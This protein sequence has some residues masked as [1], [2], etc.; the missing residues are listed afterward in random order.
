MMWE[1]RTGQT[2]DVHK[3][4]ELDLGWIMSHSMSLSSFKDQFEEWSIINI[5]DLCF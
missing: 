4:A 5:L 2:L 1:E 3:G